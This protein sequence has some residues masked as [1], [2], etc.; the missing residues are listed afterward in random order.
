MKRSIRISIAVVLVMSSSG[1]AEAHYE[2]SDP[3]GTDEYLLSQE[4]ALSIDAAKYAEIE[5]VGLEEAQ[6]RLR[7]QKTSDR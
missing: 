6:R 7:A 2:V 3:P 5:E 4:E 1:Y